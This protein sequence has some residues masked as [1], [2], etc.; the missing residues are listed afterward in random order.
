M[1][2]SPDLGSKLLKS[3]RWYHWLI[4][5]AGLALVLP[6]IENFIRGM[7]GG[8]YGR[9]FTV[10]E[11]MMTELRIVIF[12]MS[13]LILPLPS[14][15]NL[16]HDFSLSASLFSP[17][18]TFFALLFIVGLL[19]AGFHYRKK[20]PIISFGIF[21]YFLNLVIESSF[22]PLELIFEHRVYLPSVGF[23]MALVYLMDQFLYK[24][25][26]D[27]HPEIKK[28]VFLLIIIILSV[29]SV[30]T[31]LRNNDWRDR[32][33]LY[34]DSME[35]SPAKPRA[36]SNYAMAL[37]KDGQLDKCVEYGIKVQSLGEKG[38]EDF[39]NAAANTLTCLL[40]QEKHGEAI[41]IGEQLRNQVLQKNLEYIGAGALHKYMSNLARAYSEEKQY[42]KAF[43]TFQ[44]SL[45][46][47]PSEIETY[48]A[49]NR[50]L[51]YA[52][53]DE[54]GREELNIGEEIYQVPIHL[55]K[56][57]F[58]Y[59]QYDFAAK[60]LQDAIRL[61]AT[62]E[63]IKPFEEKLT[64]TIK[65]NRQQ[66]QKSNI[67]NN[68]TYKN[69]SEFRFY[70][71]AVDFILRKYKPLRGAPAGWLLNQ[72]QKIDPENPF[73]PVYRARWLLANNKADIAIQELEKKAV[74][75]NN[76]VP[77]LELLGISYQEKKNYEKSVSIFSHIL[78]IYPGYRQ[79]SSYLSYIYQ[80]EDSDNEKKRSPL[81]YY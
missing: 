47:A 51:L 78:D 16:D 19:G 37:G 28:I 66:A 62:P 33:S 72:A 23:F 18:Q 20:Y 7:S 43:D 25:A 5:I 30:L 68:P 73:I 50:L 24:F 74:I 54:Q 44:I 27:S 56:I 64:Q 67:A 77:I 75:Y 39:M 9:H 49:I 13:L 69:N 58:N 79:W 76:F 29:S 48:L 14:R 36:V 61:G 42:R 55:A 63:I 57:A 31:S 6:F 15:M 21:W 12:Y 32:L 45:F 34:R 40:M 81:D 8:F 65:Q 4:I 26:S 11:R 59:R 17:P 2:I 53:E 3:I 10:S 71:K 80:Y 22:I 60:Y 1:F 41:V 38:Y 46:R 52:Q 70:I 35:K